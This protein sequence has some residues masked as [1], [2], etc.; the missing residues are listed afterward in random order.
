MV[1]FEQLSGGDRMSAHNENK[2]SISRVLLIIICLILFVGLIVYSV[3]KVRYPVDG[4][5][6]S[7]VIV[8]E[9]SLTHSIERNKDGSF[10]TPGAKGSG[11]GKACP[12]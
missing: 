6:T 2:G 10:K 5:P 4:K 9:R 7:E 11:K 12:T 3:E 8:T 1:P